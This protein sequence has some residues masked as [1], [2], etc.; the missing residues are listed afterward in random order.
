MALF[1]V[2]SLPMLVSIAWLVSFQLITPLLNGV[3][4]HRSNDVGT[5]ADYST[6]LADD[7]AVLSPTGLSCD[8]LVSGII[9]SIDERSLSSGCTNI[10]KAPAAD[11]ARASAT[12]NSPSTLSTG[13]A[14]DWVMVGAGILLLAFAAVGCT[15]FRFKEYAFGAKGNTGTG[16]EIPYSI[17]YKRSNGIHDF[18]SDRLSA[19]V[20]DIEPFFEGDNTMPVLLKALWTQSMIEDSSEDKDGNGNRDSK[21][22]QSSLHVTFDNNVRISRYDDDHADFQVT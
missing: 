20:D 1:S 9:P 5:E 14:L 4:D 15:C 21:H 19:T 16:G 3:P 22:D 2:E 7:S 12:N 6:I 8:F 17:A 13:L 11:A 10:L 18:G